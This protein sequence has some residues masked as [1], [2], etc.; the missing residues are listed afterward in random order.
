MSA[1]YFESLGIEP[2]FSLDVAA[3]EKSFYERS[4]QLHP[5]RFANRPPEEQQRALDLSAQLND[6]YRTLRD[7]VRRA[8]YMLEQQ[9]IQ[10]SQSPPPELLE[11]VFELNMLLE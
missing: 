2:R 1:G 10:R 4:R 9:G 11:E 5:D 7:P 6:A 3:L 8:E